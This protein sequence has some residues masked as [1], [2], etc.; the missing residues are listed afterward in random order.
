[1]SIVTINRAILLTLWPADLGR[2]ATS[3]FDPQVQDCWK[4]VPEQMDD[5]YDWVSI[6]RDDEEDGGRRD[7]RYLVYQPM[8]LPEERRDVQCGV[9]VVLQ[10]FLGKHSLSPTGNWK[11]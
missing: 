2:S 10:G 1:M 7:R 9:T 6:E 8:M 4:Y 5:M 11:G 3:G